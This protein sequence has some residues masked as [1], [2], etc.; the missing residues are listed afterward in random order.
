M[1]EIPETEKEHPTFTQP[2]V[3]PEQTKMNELLRKLMDI[4][5]TLVI[6]VATCK[7][8]HKSSCQVFTKAQ[9]IAEII[10]ELQELRPKT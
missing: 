2:T 8:N 9:E 5:T 3:T 4:C 7:C 6:K 10:D 1:T